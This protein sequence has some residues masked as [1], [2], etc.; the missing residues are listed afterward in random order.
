MLAID[1]NVVIRIIALDDPEQSPRARAFVETNDVFVSAT[2]ILEA[3]W[4]LASTYR[5]PPDRVVDSLSAFLG[6]PRV[7]VESPGRVRQ[8]FDWVIA[9]LDFADALHLA[10]AGDSEGFIT[11]DS[12]LTEAAEG[13]A[14]TPVQRL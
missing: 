10:Q 1:T 4:V 13:L 8:A 14:S 7:T 5:F 6:L 2:V 3:G 11:F 12:R 9:G